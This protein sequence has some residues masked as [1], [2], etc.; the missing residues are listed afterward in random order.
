MT[1]ELELPIQDKVLK[2]LG[3]AILFVHSNGK[4]IRGNKLAY[5]IMKIDQSVAKLGELLITDYLEFNL[6]TKEADS[7]TRLLMELKNSDGKLIEVNSI[8]V[9]R[10]VY[11]LIINSFQEQT[12]PVK[13]QVDQLIQNNLEGI[14]IYNGEKI[15]D[16]DTEVA[17]MFGYLKS[18]I[19]NMKMNE[20]IEDSCV[21]KV[22]QDINN[23]PEKASSLVGIRKNG[24]TFDIDLMDHEYNNQGNMVRIALI[25]DITERVEYEK[26]LEHLAYFDELTD[27][28]NSNYF[29][30]VLRN[31]IVQA[32]LNNDEI[33]V[34]FIRF[35]YFKEINEAFG[36]NFRNKLLASCGEK[37]KEFKDANT[38]I[39]RINGDDF[40]MLQ[41]SSK[42]QNKPEELAKKLISVFEEPFKIEGYDVYITINIGISVYPDN[43][44]LATNLI[45]H[46]D[47]AMYTIKDQYQSGYKLFNS[48]ISKASKLILSM[49]SDLRKA[50]KKGEFSLHYQPQK[51]L[52]SKKLIGMEALL[53]W[54]HPEKGNIPPM[55]FIPF[56][57]K[58][59]LIIEIGDWV[60]E[61]ACR[62]NKKWQDQGYNSIVVSVNLSAKQ[63]KQIDLVDKIEKILKKTGLA[64]NYLELEITESMAMAN[65]EDILITMHC[66][67]KLGVLIS[68]D[69]FGTGYSSLKYLSVFPI[70]KLKIDKIF[71]D[72]KQKQNRSIVKSIINMSHSLNM[73]VIAE[74]VETV[75]QLTFL[76][77]ELCDEMQGYYLSKPLPPQ[78]LTQFLAKYE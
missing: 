23:Y 46:A 22:T 64:P 10:L 75:E 25:K 58:T 62:Q 48:S 40:L 65:E 47:A 9:N 59:G 28:P 45:K 44:D 35:D 57:E 30:K 51:N 63:F 27:L 4:I 39:A 33:A 18:E 73:K 66:L 31:S 37:L 69:D 19:M 1:M 24:T 54:T 56:A 12:I 32:K 70:T 76:E 2:Q 42:L 61:E 14:I 3:E 20:F 55:D 77:E 36:Y 13:K 72:E 52:K 60:I 26:H 34:Y 78:E 11:C 15:I 5:Q 7:Q 6:L 41:R 21:S 16:C 38:F 74:G 17:T 8:K 50:L 49:E 53:R 29:S 67:R 71:M 43:G 68:I